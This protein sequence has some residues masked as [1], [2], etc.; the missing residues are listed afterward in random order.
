MTSL[1]LCSLS[2]RRTFWQGITSRAECAKLSASSSFERS[3][4]SFMDF[5]N[6]PRLSL[7]V[8]YVIYIYT[9]TKQLYMHVCIYIYIVY[10]CICI[11]VGTCF[12]VFQRNG[13]SN[14][15]V[16]AS[17]R[18]L[19]LHTV[20][21]L[22]R[23]KSKGCELKVIYTHIKCCIPFLDRM[24]T[25][26]PSL[27]ITIR[28]LRLFSIYRRHVDTWIFRGNCVERKK[29]ILWNDSL[30]HQMHVPNSIRGIRASLRCFES[31]LS[32]QIRIR[33]RRDSV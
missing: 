15:I 13:D 20:S 5:A 18:A 7:Y 23:K 25:L 31:Q 9:H 3:S 4:F 2:M 10:I 24:I 28:T 8:Y 26:N 14:W 27:S 33:F 11:H 16:M 17:H 21:E 29:C 22:W 32:N 30:N 12:R 6:I 19:R 1:T